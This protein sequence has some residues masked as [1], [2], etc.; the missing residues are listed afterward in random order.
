MT[1][2]LRTAVMAAAVLLASAGVSGAQAPRANGETLRIQASSGIVSNMHAVVAQKKGFCEKY[3]FK[4][5]LKWPE[6]AVVGL[7]ELADKT[8]DI[9]Q[10]GTE[11]IAARGDSGLVL[12][13]LSL[14]AVMHSLNIRSDVPL[15]NFFKGYPEM[16]KDFKGLKIGVTQRGAVGE[17]IFTA[18][19]REA[20]LQPSDVTYVAVGGAEAAYTAMVEA[21]Q[22]DAAM[23]FP[24]LPFLC[25]LHKTC[26]PVID[27]TL[28]EGPAAIRAMTGATVVFA[29]RREMADGNPQLM[30]AFYAAFRDAAAWFN[31]PFNLE[32]LVAIYA[33]LS[34][35]GNQPAANTIL[36][37]WIIG[38]IP[39]YSQ[40][41]KINRSSVDSIVN[42]YTRAGLITRPVDTSRLVWDK[43]P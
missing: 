16:L 38:V 2:M 8:I 14:S 20:G 41:L 25:D 6:A 34:G 40:D 12:V 28:G 42:F 22:I 37:N 35:L 39:V 31:D 19:L 29:A 3:N 15:P 24:P 36:R 7:Q 23:M 10:L 17:L 13:G 1:G 9:A 32:E 43:A 30:A 27:M 4:C 11:Q 26:F 21:R 33:P 18:M 5:E